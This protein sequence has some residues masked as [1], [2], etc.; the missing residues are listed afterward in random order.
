LSVG[1]LG[2]NKAIYLASMAAM[3]SG[4]FTKILFFISFITLKD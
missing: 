3:Y 4:N 2:S 1:E